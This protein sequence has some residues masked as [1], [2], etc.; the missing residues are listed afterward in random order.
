MSHSLLKVNQH[1]KGNKLPAFTLVSCLTYSM[2]LKM[3]AT[4]SSKTSV[5]SEQTTQHYAPEDMTHHKQLLE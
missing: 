5:D 1:F 4:Y 3:E 2:T